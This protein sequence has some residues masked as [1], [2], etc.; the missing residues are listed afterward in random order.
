MGGGKTKLVPFIYLN[1]PREPR[2]RLIEP[3]AGSAALSLGLDFDA[4][5]LSDS[6]PD[7]IGLYLT[8]KNER[9]VFIDYARS[10][11]IADNNQEHVFYTLRA[12]FGGHRV[13]HGVAGSGKTLILGIRSQY[14]AEQSNKPVLVLCY[15][16]A[17]AAKLRALIADKGLAEK[18]QVHH[19]HGWCSDLLKAHHIP[20]LSE[21]QKLPFYER[22]VQTL[23]RA[24]QEKTL[25]E[26]LYGAVLI[27]EGHDFDSDWLRLAV[28][29]LDQ[30]EGNLLLLYDDAQSIYKR[31]SLG[32]SL[33]SVGIK[34]QGRTT[35]LRL[36][37]RNT[38]E[39]I[40]FAYL[41]A[42]NKMQPR[43]SSENEIPLLE[44]EAAGESGVSPYL[45]KC[46]D[47]QA[48]LDFLAGRLDKWLSE[49]F[50]LQDIAVIC[51]ESRQ[52]DD[53]CEL[54]KRKDIPHQALQKSSNRKK[55]HPKTEAITVC[56]MHS[57]KGLEFQRVMLMGINT[58]KD[59]TDQ[60]EE[61]G[62]RLLYVAMTRAQSYL[63]ITLTGENLFVQRLQHSC[64]QFKE[65]GD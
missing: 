47:W 45:R 56:T 46:D 26:N 9:Q 17:L 51:H 15:N 22:S 63:M 13:I 42:Q 10:F 24:M 28:Y 5:L 2:R 59:K 44:P 23:V 54:L 36:N 39:I 18:V 21:E 57:S 41:F 49:G 14:L 3:F 11:F 8:L 55:Y 58:L 7:L 35:V 20:L 1:M 61:E 6:N 62:T 48:E 29:T 12:R 38:K 52:C 40:G 65:N 34:A 30:E 31:G 27:D 25:P 19:F 64:R 16:V 53:V 43:E 50:A 37:Y 4:Y 32:F 33:A 60:Q